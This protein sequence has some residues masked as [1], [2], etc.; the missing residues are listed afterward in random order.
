[1]EDRRTHTVKKLSLVLLALLPLVASGCIHHVHH[2]GHRRSALG[3]DAEHGAKHWVVVER[4]QHKKL[5]KLLES[6]PDATLRYADGPVAIYE[7][8]VP[9]PG[10]SG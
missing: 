3:L 9:K 8:D 7:I 1:M 4:D 10:P 6:A 2:A 5:S